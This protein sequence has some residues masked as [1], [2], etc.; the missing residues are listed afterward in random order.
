[1][2]G[3]RTISVPTSS[4]VPVITLRT[5]GGRI[6]DAI[7]ASRSAVSGVLADGFRT[8]VLPMASAGPTFQPAI[9]SG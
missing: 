5:P 9:M 2:P 6:S 7:S 1:M 4:P 3:W 8:T